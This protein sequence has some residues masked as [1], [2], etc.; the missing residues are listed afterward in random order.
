MVLQRD[1]QLTRHGNV[2][3]MAIMVFIALL[4]IITPSV[5]LAATTIENRLCNAITITFYKKADKTDV[6]DTLGIKGSQ[7]VAYPEKWALVSVTPQ[8]TLGC[9]PRNDCAFA[10]PESY[11]CSLGVSCKITVSGDAS[12]LGCGIGYDGP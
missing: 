4:E 9:T 12:G 5:C 8:S 2:I 3:P 10:T 11:R 1:G 7:T 6:Q